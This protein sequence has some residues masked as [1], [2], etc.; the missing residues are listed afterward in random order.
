MTTDT[1]TLFNA[2]ATHNLFWLLATEINDSILYD[3]Y[4]EAKELAE[5]IIED[6]IISDES[7]IEDLIDAYAGCND[8]WHPERDWTEEYCT[9]VGIIDDNH[10]LYNFIDFQEVWDRLLYY[11]FFT[12]ITKN[13]TYF[14]HNY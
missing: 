7:Q 2:T 4:D 12:V 8:G 5:Q 14:F 6:G 3:D 11:D 10:T 1:R 9:E 13:C